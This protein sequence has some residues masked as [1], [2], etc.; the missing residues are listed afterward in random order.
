VVNVSRKL[1]QGRLEI[2]VELQVAGKESLLEA[3]C[4]FCVDLFSDVIVHDVHNGPPILV[5]GLGKSIFLAVIFPKEIAISLDFFGLL[6]VTVALC[7][8]IEN[9]VSF[10]N[11]VINISGKGLTVVAAPG[12]FVPIVVLHVISLSGSMACRVFFLTVL[13][14][15]FPY[16]SRWDIAQTKEAETVYPNKVEK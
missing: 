14:G 15:I 10:V 1:L 13:Y 11:D 3:R 2:G 4:E 12:F 16:K 8:S 5:I 9:D 6:I 7:V